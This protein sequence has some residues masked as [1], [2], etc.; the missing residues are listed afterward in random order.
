[1]VFS[2]HVYNISRSGILESSK[3]TTFSNLS[4]PS[5]D[6]RYYFQSFLSSAE[7]KVTFIGLVFTETFSPNLT[8]EFTLYLYKFCLSDFLQI[9]HIFVSLL[10]CL[11]L[12][13]LEDCYIASTPFLFIL[14]SNLVIFKVFQKILRQI[15]AF[16]VKTV[17]YG[18]SNVPQSGSV[19]FAVA[20]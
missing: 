9:L 16:L 20:V 13:Q 2:Y 1:M 3:T 12:S 17:S 4:I 19:F 11:L 5:S 7:F 14:F 6:E 18:S 10:L 8:T 15:F